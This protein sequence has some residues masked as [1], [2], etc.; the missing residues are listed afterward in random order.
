MDID[1][2]GESLVEQLVKAG[3][4]R[5]VADLYELDQPKLLTLPRVGKK[6]ADNLLASISKSKAQ[7]LSRLLTGLGIDLLGQVAATQLARAFGELNALLA[8]PPETIA[9][10]AADIAGFGPKMVES[11][12]SYLSDP[13]EQQ[14]LA[15]LAALGVS[16]PEPMPTSTAGGH[17]DG[18]SFCVTGVLSR[19]REAV[20]EDIRGHGGIVTGGC[21]SQAGRLTRPSPTATRPSAA[22]DVTASASSPPKLRDCSATSRSVAARRWRNDPSNRDCFRLGS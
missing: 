17:L 8:E 16:T 11:L 9:K 2:L 19:K 14:L 15:R 10:K 7:P 21:G 6:S 20:H 1:H 13:E 3:L 22:S 12:L 4:V 18:K 5:R